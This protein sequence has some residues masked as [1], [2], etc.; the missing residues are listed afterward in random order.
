ML[1]YRTQWQQLDYI[2]F[3]YHFTLCYNFSL[4]LFSQ[5]VLLQSRGNIPDLHLITCTYYPYVKYRN[6]T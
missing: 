2:M 4:M 3:V 6:F 5:P 1:I